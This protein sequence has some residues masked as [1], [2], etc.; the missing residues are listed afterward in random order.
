MNYY[1]RGLFMAILIVNSYYSVLREDNILTKDKIP[2]Y[3]EV[4]YMRS[5]MLNHYANH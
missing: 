5:A 3:I 4:Q 2:L 1:L